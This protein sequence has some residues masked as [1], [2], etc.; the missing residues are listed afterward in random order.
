MS[1]GIVSAE[2]KELP[3][4]Q[5]NGSRKGEAKPHLVI[6]ALAKILNYLKKKLIQVSLD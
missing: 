5:S 1:C 6:F 3:A 4:P 2:V